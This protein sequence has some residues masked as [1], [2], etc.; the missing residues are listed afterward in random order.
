MTAR[1]ATSNARRNPRR[2][3]AITTALMIGVALMS[4]FT[5]ILATL[6]VQ[7]TSELAENFPVDFVIDPAT[8][9]RDRGTM[10]E[11][12]AE[13][14]RA[15]PELGRWSTRWPPRPAS[16]ASGGRSARSG[17]RRSAPR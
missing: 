1:L 9:N 16:P 3:S 6:K 15:R 10:P 14:L 4:M 12:L 8:Y 13:Q 11:G 7:R 5:V 2:A 17:R